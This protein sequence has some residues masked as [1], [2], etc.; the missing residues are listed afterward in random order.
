M[1]ENNVKKIF[2]SNVLTLLVEKFS[3]KRWF[4]FVICFW[5]L[6]GPILFVVYP[7]IN[8]LLSNFISKEMIVQTLDE[9]DA[10]KLDEHR[11]MFEYS[12]QTYGIVKQ[13]MNE[14]I[15]KIDAQYLFLIE[16]HNGSEN[17]MTGIQFCRFDVTVEICSDGNEFIPIEKF[18]DDIV[19]RYDLLLSQDLNNDKVYVY[20]K[21]NF[22]DIDKYLSYQLKSIEAESFSIVNLRDKNGKVFGSLISIS[23]NEHIDRAEMVICAKKI[24]NVFKQFSSGEGRDSI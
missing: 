10:Q 16:Y 15:D 14:Y 6:V 11:K 21:D 18:K 22:D 13:T 9:R 24:E 5:F 20:T 1:E 17:V 19:A 7:V 3:N 23:K 12:R 2:N 4:Q 8:T